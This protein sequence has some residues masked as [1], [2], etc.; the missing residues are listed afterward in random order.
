MEFRS[1]KLS[2]GIRVLSEK[3]T[4]TRA[5]SL[6][7]WVNAG[8]G[9]EEKPLSGVSHLIEHLVFKGTEK[10][11]SFQI[12][13]MLEAV[14]AEI[15]AFTSREHTCFYTMSLADHLDLS[16]NILTDLVSGA[17]FPVEEYEKERDVVI[18]EI[19]MGED[20]PEEHIFDVFFERAFKTLPVGRPI[21][22]TARSLK[23]ISQEQVKQYYKFRYTGENI[24]VAAA[25]NIDHE[26]LEKK[27]EAL[28]GHLPPGQ[29][30]LKPKVSVMKPFVESIYRP[31]EHVH[32]LVGLPA[33]RFNDQWRNEGLL[34]SGIAGGGM[35]SRFYQEIR[36]KLGLAYSVY[37][38]QHTQAD[39]GVEFLYS[40]TEPKK[41]K[42]L[43]KALF[44]EMDRFYN[45]GVSP[46][47]V[48]LIK[49][50]LKGQIILAHEDLEYRMNSIAIGELLVGRPRSL[51]EVIAEIDSIK[52]DRVNEY[53][54]HYWNKDKLG[55][56]CMGPVKQREIEY[57]LEQV[58]A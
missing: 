47:E 35:S 41:L 28:L 25:G 4:D 21:W 29:K 39:T 14:G 46:K 17:T 24:I 23:A 40:S 5:L 45:H 33:P 31:L 26:N 44:S 16:L 50:Q 36:E 13:S 48:E 54:K 19:K 42:K 27:I 9:D 49:T 37:S 57:L 12:V 43:L 15:N 10:F 18:Q 56:L 30:T 8:S 3:H 22:G 20:S 2:N 32:I 58:K 51:E 55:I 11:N 6:G 7:I 34:A 53:L 1:S 52:I 38:Y